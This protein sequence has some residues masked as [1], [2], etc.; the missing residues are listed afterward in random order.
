MKFKWTLGLAAVAVISAM[1]LVH[2]VQKATTG[3][4][5]TGKEGT[6]QAS[7]L[8]LSETQIPNAAQEVGQLGAIAL[9]DANWTHIAVPV[10]TE[11]VAH[12]NHAAVST[13]KNASF[14]ASAN[15]PNTATSDQVA[16]RAAMV[17]DQLA[18][19]CLTATAQFAFTATGALSSGS[20]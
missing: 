16:T 6:A 9:N 1:A 17:T 7:E 12:M 11:R 3:V 4:A 14:V 19:K 15:A 8:A 10:D 13:Q 5:T 18:L 2:V 20:A